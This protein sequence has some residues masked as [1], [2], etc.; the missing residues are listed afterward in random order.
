[1][2]RFDQTGPMGQGAMTGRRMGRCM[3]QDTNRNVADSSASDSNFSAT[4]FRGRGMGMGRGMTV[5]GR[6]R[7]GNFGMDCRAGFGG[8]NRWNG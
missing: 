6:G 2:P 1:M 7:G 5:G 3:Q 4:N 8:G